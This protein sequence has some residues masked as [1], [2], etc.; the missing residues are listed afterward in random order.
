MID[1]LIKATSI[2]VIATIGLPALAMGYVLMLA[3]LLLTPLDIPIWIVS[4][5]TP[6]CDVL[7][8]LEKT[9]R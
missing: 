6:V 8:K 2:A 4:G 1:R 5:K 3:L 9:L 7:H